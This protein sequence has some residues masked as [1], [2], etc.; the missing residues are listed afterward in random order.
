MHLQ[1]M[2]HTIIIRPIRALLAFA[3]LAVFAA[4]CDVNQFAGPQPSDRQQ[5]PPP[6]GRACKPSARLYAQIPPRD[7]DK[8]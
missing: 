6:D 2:T 1:A 7:C 4:G 5:E 3:L 8:E